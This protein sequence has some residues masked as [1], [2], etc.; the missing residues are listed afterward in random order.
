MRLAVSIVAAL[1]L[2]YRILNPVTMCYV[3]GPRGGLYPGPLRFWPWQPICGENWTLSA[4]MTLLLAVVLGAVFVWA[5]RGVR[6]PDG[7][8]LARRFSPRTKSWVIVLCAILVATA[9]G[10]QQMRSESWSSDLRRELAEQAHANTIVEGQ[11]LGVVAI[12]M[13]LNDV[14]S[15]MS[16]PFDAA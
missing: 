2:V 5:V 8:R 6:V 14:K 12:G 9:W 1:A 11:H 15:K 13:N 10:Y 16:H 7:A 4:W 3:L